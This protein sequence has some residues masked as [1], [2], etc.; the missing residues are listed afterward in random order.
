M[1]DF[2]TPSANDWLAVKQFSV[3]ENKHARRPDV[4][5]STTNALLAISDRVE[6]RVGPK[7]MLVRA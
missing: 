2:D 3:K 5:L 6:A 4:V 7:P 1:I